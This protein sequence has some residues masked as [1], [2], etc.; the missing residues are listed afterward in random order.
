MAAAEGG[1]D[2][3]VLAF[4]REPDA[5]AA[6]DEMSLGMML[7]RR[8]VGC[9]YNIILV[10]GARRK[11]LTLEGLWETRCSWIVDGESRCA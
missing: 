3:S 2:W 8:D 10:V 9:Q 6:S 4:A 11:K 7:G 1:S 5:V